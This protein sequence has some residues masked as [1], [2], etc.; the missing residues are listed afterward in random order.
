MKSHPEVSV[1]NWEI[2][3]RGEAFPP[4]RGWGSTGHSL[5]SE[6]EPKIT[7][8]DTNFI[9][10]SPARQFQPGTSPEEQQENLSSVLWCCPWRYQIQRENQEAP[11][12]KN[13][14]RGTWSWVAFEGLRYRVNLSK[15]TSRQPSVQW[16][17]GRAAKNPLNIKNTDRSL[18]QGTPSWPQHLNPRKGAAKRKLKP[19]AGKSKFI[20]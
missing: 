9:F 13:P 11:A 17:L 15:G 10:R 7:Q 6:F 1:Q 5:H 4:S 14:D 20:S 16:E 12:H 8:S 18:A 2:G 19:K 3:I